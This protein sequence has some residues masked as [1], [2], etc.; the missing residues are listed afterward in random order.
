MKIVG[1]SNLWYLY[2]FI[3]LAKLLISSLGWF[4]LGSYYFFIRYFIWGYQSGFQSVY[5]YIVDEMK[6]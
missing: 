6:R 5:C 4:A 2:L 1:K 3:L